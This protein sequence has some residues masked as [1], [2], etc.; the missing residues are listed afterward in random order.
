MNSITSGYQEIIDYYKQMEADFLN[1]RIQMLEMTRTGKDFFA[2]KDE[3][4]VD[5]MIESF[6]AFDEVFKKMTSSKQTV[7]STDLLGSIKTGID[8]YRSSFVEVVELSLKEIELTE[9]AREQS[10]SLIKRANRLQ[11][12]A[13]PSIS[14]LTEAARLSS[15][16]SEG[17]QYFSIFS[18]ENLSNMQAL[19]KLRPYSSRTGSQE[20]ISQ[21]EQIGQIHGQVRNKVESL[22]L[23]LMKTE[24]SIPK[25]SSCQSW[26]WQAYDSHGWNGQHH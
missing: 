3:I 15:L 20:Y 23:H 21:A 9:A 26:G 25:E 1:V 12:V 17:N 18:E 19:E 2:S 24:E 5:L 10:V 7:V 8:N 11:T 13:E 16:V 6:V 4:Y 22:Q 14:S